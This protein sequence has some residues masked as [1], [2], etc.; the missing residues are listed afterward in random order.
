MEAICSYE[1][2]IGFQYATWH[3]ITEG[4]NRHIHHCENLNLTSY[5]GI[6]QLIQCVQSAG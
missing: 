5:K 4:I 2:S 3:I 6:E 1:T